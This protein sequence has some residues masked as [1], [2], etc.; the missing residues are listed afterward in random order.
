MGDLGRLLTRLDDDRLRR[1][2]QFERV[3][4]WFLTNDP[5]YQ[6]QVQRVRLWDDWPGR[7]GADAGIDLVVED[8]EGGL[9]AVQAKAYDPDYSVTKADVDTFLSESS[10]PEFSYRLLI[11]T[12]NRVGQ[13]ARRTLASQEK[14]AGLLLLADLEAAQVDWPS[15]PAALRPKAP[16]RKRPRPHQTEAIR[17]VVKGFAAD[18]RGQ[19]IMACG[20]GKTLTALFVAERLGAKRTLVLVPSLSLLAQTLREWTANASEGFDCL[21]VCSDDTV[22]EPDAAVNSTSDLGFPVTTD[23]EA[24]ARFLR[25]RAGRQV[26]FSTY[27]SSPR[28]AEAYRSG[29]VPRLDFAIADEAHRC[30][31]RV[32]SDFATILDAGAIPAKRRLFM[33]AT[34]RYFTGRVV[35]E[36]READFEVASM[37]DPGTF[38]PVFHRLTFGEAIERDLLSDYQVAVIGVDDATYREWAEHG[39]FVTLDGKAVTDARSLAGQIGLAKAMR[40]YG[41][42]RTISFHSRVARA[43][44]FARSLTE[45]VEWMPKR[46]RPKGSLW[47]THVSGEMST[48]QRTISLER[49]RQL[50]DDAVGLL[51]NARCLAEGVDVP[52]LDGVAFIDPR[53]SEVD[54][55]QAVGRAIRKAE[56]KT[57]GTI[58]IP[59]FIGA[60]EDP[61]AALDDSTFKPV[62][63]VIRALRAHDADLAEQLDSLRRE[64]GRGASSVRIPP[65]LHLDL[66]AHVGLDFASALD[67]RLVE[68]TTASWEFWLGLLGA[69]VEREGHCRVPTDYAVRDV[70]L[71]GWCVSCRSARRAGKLDAGRIAVLDALGFVWDP[72][73][74]DFDR[75]LAELAAYV[76]ARGHARVPRDYASPTGFELEH[77]CRNRSSERKAGN[78]DADRVA[79]LDALGFVWDRRQDVLYRGLAELAC[80]V[81]RHGNARVRQGYAAPSGF[82]LGAWCTERRT[83]YRNGR[84]GTENVAALEALGFEWDPRQEKFDRGVGELATYVRRHG[85]ARVPKGYQT[86]SGFNLGDWCVSRRASRK[87]ETL[88][89]EDIA[90]LDALGFVWDPFQTAFDRGLAELASYVHTHGNAR[91][92]TGFT[93]PARF[94]LWSWCMN[95]RQRYRAGMLSPDRAAA[96]SALGFV[97]DP[98]Q[99]AFDRGLAELA[100]YVKAHG[101][102]Q[103]PKSYLS[104]SGLKLGDWCDSR[105]AERKA[106]N[107]SADRIAALDALGFAWSLQQ[108]RFDLGLSELAAYIE[109]HRDADVPVKYSTQSG[110]ALGSWCSRRRA[111][112]RAGTLS[113][114][115]I[116]ALDALGFVWESRQTRSGPSRTR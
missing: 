29:R 115:R 58:V 114:E 76:R 23:A 105:R 69:F 98:Y 43:R 109:T 66:P 26:V 37:D 28:I 64:L 6:H 95:Q 85:D 60:D 10:R 31:G 62:W 70:K 63:D 57:T 20:T 33:T 111:E 2:K 36:A 107:L 30:A 90:A 46:Q 4:K 100:A 55:V 42:R 8:R 5:L 44:D 80:Y 18:D 113:A 40:R 13:T 91:V 32:S 1:G 93:T 41:L 92:P 35:R 7:W 87:A 50:D 116:A 103:V 89:A 99:E 17:A 12:T 81:R 88:A 78:L 59:V 94:A 49:L 101:D 67:V 27:Q 39:R 11:A 74:D 19:M 102:A 56:N 14:Q 61:E 24:I 51:A 9:W 72:W 86:S 53:R 65:K 47:A 112:R 110:F 108:E 84:L 3:C 82:K 21:A 77:W 106:S 104:P 25:R 34:P 96:L 16:K 38:G 83:E 15:S 22:I 73:Q 54:I 71:G 97:W 75:G 79:A 48:G 45:V 68:Q 52:T